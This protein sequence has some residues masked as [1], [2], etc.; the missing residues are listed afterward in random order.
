MFIILLIVL[1]LKGLTYAFYICDRQNAYNPKLAITVGSYCGIIGS[2]CVASGT[3]M[4]Y[5]EV[6][7]F[8]DMQ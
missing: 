1:W 2:L 4:S 7:R 8:V 3:L 6:T 5:K